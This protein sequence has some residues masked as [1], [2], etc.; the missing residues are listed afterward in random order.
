VSNET[1][2]G[3]ISR[4]VRQAILADPGPADFE[5]TAGLADL[6][7][8]AESAKQVT[9]SPQAA[10]IEFSG[11]ETVTFGDVSASIDSV[12][13]LITSIAEQTRLLALNATIEAARAGA[14]GQGFA[15][16]AAEVKSL[17]QES[18]A[19][20]EEI[21]KRVAAIQAVTAG[22]TTGIVDEMDR[23]AQADTRAD[24]H[25]TTHHAAA[26]L[27]TR[28]RSGAFERAT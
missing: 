16:V 15:V 2:D 28:P 5:I 13:T 17:A 8:R 3:M 22:M 24:G 14:A 19:A 27:R 7:R 11:V 4:M 12:V 1:A 25:T 23:I 26:E 18:A 6:Y 21:T 20:V 10:E 9:A